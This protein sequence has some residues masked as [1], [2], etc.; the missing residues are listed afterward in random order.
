MA[1]QYDTKRYEIGDIVDDMEIIEIES[2]KDKHGKSRILY[3]LRCTKCGRTKRK[4]KSYLD[5][6]SG[7]SHRSCAEQIQPKDNNYKRFRRIWECMRTRTTNPN[8]K[9]W[10]DYKNIS[11]EYYKDFI[12]FYD[13]MYESYLEHVKLHGDDT[14]IDRINP[15]GNYEPNNIRWATRKV[16]NQ[17][18]GKKG[19]KKRIGI[20]PNNEK[21][22][23]DNNAEFAKEHNL[24]KSKIGA[25]LRGERKSHKGWTFMYED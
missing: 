15:E 20:S 17:P 23:F 11:S 4:R 16:Q 1:N 18:K 22:T 21:F 7:T 5:Q 6:H 25:V 12:D 24:E 2:E 3:T 13:D 9:S 10:E 14:S 19:F 8:Q